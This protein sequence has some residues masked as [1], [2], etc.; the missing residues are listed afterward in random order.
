MESTTLLAG[1]VAE[2]VAALESI[3]V[4]GPLAAALD[5]LKNIPLTGAQ[6]LAVLQAGQRQINHYTGYKLL[7]VEAADKHI[8]QRLLAEPAFQERHPGQLL[9]QEL[10]AE[11]KLTRPQAAELVNVSLEIVRRQEQVWFAMC[12]GLLDEQRALVFAQSLDGLSFEHATAVI[13]VVLPRA[14]ALT[15]GS[16]RRRC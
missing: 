3:P 14:A 5:G 11:L 15:T 2:R 16:W 4:G 8:W 6:H 12:H 1:S 10:A 7:H 13:D 9:E